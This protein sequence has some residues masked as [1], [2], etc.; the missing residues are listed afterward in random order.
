MVILIFIYVMI[1]ILLIY[2]K[3]DQN[4]SYVYLMKYF[5]FLNISSMLCFLFIR[6]LL[7]NNPHMGIYVALIIPTFMLFVD[8]FDVIE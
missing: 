3:Y 1:L 2:K 5:I 8:T 4:K 6:S 7:Q